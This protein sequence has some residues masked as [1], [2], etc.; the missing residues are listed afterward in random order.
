MDQVFNDPVALRPYIQDATDP[1]VSNT[2]LSV[3][4]WVDAPRIHSPRAYELPIVRIADEKPLLRVI[5]VLWKP[6]ITE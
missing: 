2:R 4:D 5:S 3:L 1:A 6:V